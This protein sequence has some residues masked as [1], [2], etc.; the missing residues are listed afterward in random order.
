M[1]GHHNRAPRGCDRTKHLIQHF[2]RILVEPRV[3]FIEQH[4]FRVVD[5][6]APDGEPLLHAARKSADEVLAAIFQPDHLKYLG[7]PVIVFRNSVH[8]RVELQ[9]FLRRQVRIEQREM[10]DHT[11]FCPHLGGFAGKLMACN[12]DRSQ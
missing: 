10:R 1:R 2:G 6:R 11:Q 7:N 8:A 9:V 4:H 12:S 5:H 3:G